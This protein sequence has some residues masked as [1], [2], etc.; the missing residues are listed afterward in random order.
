M[1]TLKDSA[2]LRPN[3][4]LPNA[5]LLFDNVRPAMPVP[6]SVECCG[7]V[8][9]LSKSVSVPVCAPSAAGMNATPSVQVALGARVIG[10]A[11][12]VPVPLNAYSAGS[13]DVELEMIS[14]RVAPVLSTVRFLVSVW[15]TA[16][17]PN[18]SDAVTDME[19]VGVA[20]GVAVA[21][22][23]A[24]AVWVAVAVP[25][26]VP[27]TVAVLVAVGVAVLVTVEVAVTVCV[28]VAVLV[29]VG[30]EELVAVAVAVAVRVTVAVAV[31]VVVFVA[32]GVD[33]G[34][35]PVPNAIT[36]AE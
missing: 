7:L 5:R 15:P 25:V 20:V 28:G 22:V 33:E 16:T 4:S 29:E 11:P 6:V 13:D 19:V 26:G 10:I 8:V 23:V 1:V 35:P 27:V 12:H 3:F 32:V 31:G 24:V 9:A 36:L 14:E 2:A 18:A 21:I 30:V 34:D 17:L